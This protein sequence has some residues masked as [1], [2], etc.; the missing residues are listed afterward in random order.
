MLKMVGFDLDDTLYYHWS[1][2]KQIFYKISIVVEKKYGINREKYFE[3]L[4]S[5]FFQK[6]KYRTFDYALKNLVHEIPEDWDNFVKDMIL[7]IYRNFKPKDK[8]EKIEENFKIMLDYY[9]KKIPLFLVTN[10]NVNVQKNKIDKLEIASYF[11]EI[12][13]SDFFGKEYRKPNT[14]MFSYILEK[15]NLNP[16][17]VIYYG[18]DEKIDSCSEI[19]GIKFINISKD[20]RIF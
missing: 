16:N 11:D 19:L 2:E 6:N 4:K 3:N 20:R 12:L 9:T 1:F 18:D 17:E 13:I 10:G 5:L 8:L 7:P 14:Y 15:Y